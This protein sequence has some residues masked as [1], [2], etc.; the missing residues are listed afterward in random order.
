MQAY[1]PVYDTIL[2]IYQDQTKN[3]TAQCPADSF[4][5]PELLSKVDKVQNLE[6]YYTNIC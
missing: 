2:Y 4:D 3:K 6:Q 1:S 5:I